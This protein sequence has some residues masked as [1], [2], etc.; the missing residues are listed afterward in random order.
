MGRKLSARL[1]DPSGAVKAQSDVILGPYTRIDLDL[2]AD[3]QPGAYTLAVV[4][5]D[6]VTLAPFP[7]SAGN[8]TTALSTI[9][10]LGDAAR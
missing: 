1:V 2:P 6:P 7:D 8:F 3:A 5:Y 10:V 4:L 9:D